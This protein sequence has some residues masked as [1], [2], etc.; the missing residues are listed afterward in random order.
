M[1]RS[2]KISLLTLMLTVS[3]VGSVWAEC[4]VG[5]LSGNCQVD[6]PDLMVFAGQWLDADTSGEGLV[7]HWKLDGNAADP[8]GGNHGT[9]YGSPLWTVG[10]VDGALYFDGDGDYIDCGNDSSLNLTNNFSI[11]AW[12]NSDNVEPVLLICKGNVP[13][14]DPGGAYT[15]LCVPSNGIIA[16]YVRDSGNTNFGYAVTAVSLNQ[17]VHVV[18]TFSDGNINIYKNG[19]FVQSGVLGTTTIYSNDGPLGIGADGDGGMLFTGTID[20][21]RIY[22]RAMSEAEARKIADLGMPD[23]NSADLDDNGS[24]NLFDYTQLADHWQERGN[25]LVINEFMASN[26]SSNADPQ[27]HYDDWIEIY[28]NGSVAIDIGGMYLTDDLDEP[29][30]WRIPDNSPN[31]T[32]IGPYE[33]LLIWADKESEDGPLHVEFKLDGG[34]EEIGLFDTDGNTLRH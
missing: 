1:P 7:A 34:G 32:T 16:F 6:L 10:K 17:W 21:V 14:Y 30:M 11:S 5:D 29:M 24:V 4:P 25:P 3:L 18:V 8:I 28:N 2:I 22:N 31:D 26:S 9:I 33:Y 13:A 12:F 23:P 15:V 27:G 20:D 19:V